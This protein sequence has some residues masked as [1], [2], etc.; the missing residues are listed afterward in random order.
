VAPA[1]RRR[2]EWAGSLPVKGPLPVE[3]RGNTRFLEVHHSVQ[4]GNGYAQ[5]EVPAILRSFYDFHVSKAWPDIAYN[6]L[7]DRFG[8][9]WEGRAGSLDAP[10]IPSATGGHQGFSQKVCFIGD[11]RTSAPTALMTDRMVSALARLALRYGIPTAPGSTATFVSRGSGKLPRGT[12]CTLPTIV[13]H[14][15]VAVTACPGDAANHQVVHVYPAAVTR[16]VTAPP[17]PP[18]RPK[19]RHLRM[20]PPLS[21]H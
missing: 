8:T 6:F 20:P 10:V 1:I 3:A 7:V 2:A 11:H 17:P 13:G 19:P 12:L 15:A 21:H 18:P 16:I 5:A 4:P 9:I 14:R